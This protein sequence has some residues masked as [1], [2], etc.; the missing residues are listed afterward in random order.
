LAFATTNPDAQFMIFFIIPIK[1][2]VMALIYLLLVI[3]EIYNY[4][5][6]YL[7]FPHNLFPLVALANYLIFFFNDIPNLLPLSWRAK[8]HR[9]QQAKTSTQ[10]KT[11]SI[12]FRQ[13]PQKA[14]FMH[15]CTVCGK[16][17]RT[18]P[19]LEF[20]YCSR[21]SGYHCYC[22]A[23]ISNHDHIEI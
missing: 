7:F 16:T 6:P 11:G 12:P 4:T 20:R 1:A 18:N 13:P 19:E 3:V 2:W 15:R 5:F 8:R 10:Q 17:D 9:K 21:C 22:Q 14:D 23:H